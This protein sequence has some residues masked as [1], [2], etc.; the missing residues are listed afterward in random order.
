[1]ARFNRKHVVILLVLHLCVLYFINRSIPHTSEQRLQALMNARDNEVAKNGNTLG[2]NEKGHV[3]YK[4]VKSQGIVKSESQGEQMKRQQKCDNINRQHGEFVVIKND[5]FVY[6]SY[7]DQ[8]QELPEIRI[9]TIYKS[10]SSSL[11]TSGL[12]CHFKVNSLGKHSKHAS[13]LAKFYKMCEH[14][15]KEYGGYFMSC[16]LPRNIKLLPRSLK[17]GVGNTTTDS[18]H[19]SIEICINSHDL[20]V[21]RRTLDFGVCVPPLHGYVN[22]KD[23]IEFVELHRLLGAEIFTFYVGDLNNSISREVHQIIKHYQSKN[24]INTVHLKLPFD[25]KRI[26]YHAQSVAMNDCLYKNMANFRYIAFLD[27]DEVLVPYKPEIASWN[28]LIEYFKNTEE[29]FES[30]SG[31]TFQ[32]TFF[33]DQFSRKVS[34]SEMKTN[35]RTNR[36]KNFSIFR[37][38]LIVRPDRVFE[39]G[40]HHISKSWP[41][42]ANYRTLRVKPEVARVHHYRKCIREFGI[43]CTSRVRDDVLSRKFGQNLIDNFYKTLYDIT[44]S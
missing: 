5:L 3:F 11:A 29:D 17:I 39:I 36:T 8:R 23:I 40:I 35:V 18:I 38:K 12:K 9:I 28:D 21:V 31:Y 37:N 7:I 41:T 34:S 32:S 20:N 44:P 42:E 14:H 1:M 15:D 33:D 16:P 10:N 22:P 27:I 6:S 4:K 13:S 43:H 25:K 19:N 26:W 24:I 2:W 30:F